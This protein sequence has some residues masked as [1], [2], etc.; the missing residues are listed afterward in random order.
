MADSEDMSRESAAARRSA[1]RSMAT[2]PGELVGGYELLR[3][4]GRGGM[5]EVWVARKA[6]S[7][8]GKFVALKM[9]LPQFVGDE[10]YSRMFR[11]EAEV[12]A[13]LSHSNIVQVFDEGEDA[14]RS[15]LV[16]EWVDGVDLARLAPDLANLRE[17]DPQ[18]RLRVI[19]YVVGQVLHGLS[20]AHKITSHRGQSLGIV[21]RD[22]SPQ[23]VIVSV[24]GDVKVTD[25]GIAHRMIEETSGIHVKGKL[26]YMAPEHLAGQSHSPTVDLYAVGAILH[27]LLEGRK[28]RH[29]AQDQVQLYHQ[30]MTG[31]IPD[32]PADAPR[33]L[34]DLRLALLQPD[35]KKRPQ[36]AD[37]ALLM[38]KRWPGYSEMKVEL[39]MICGM[40]TGI[41]RPRT[42]PAITG[43]SIVPPTP[44][45][46]PEIRPAAGTPVSGTAPTAEQHDAPAP[47]A[48]ATDEAPPATEVIDPEVLRQH[49]RP[50]SEPTVALAG[51]ASTG[52]HATEPAPVDPRD[53][54][55]THSSIVG[56]ASDPG[57]YGTT[58]HVDATISRILIPAVEEPPRRR[59][60]IAVVG[61]AASLA[62]LAGGAAAWFLASEAEPDDDAHVLVE[63]RP[64][65]TPLGSTAREPVVA[66]PS[67]APVDAAPKPASAPVEPTPAPIAAQPTA[68]ASAEPS[69]PASTPAP[70]PVEPKRAEDRRSTTP[71]KPEP[72]PTGP[73]VSV[74]YRLEGGLEY[75]EVKI[76]GVLMKLD[77]RY[78]SKLPSGKHSV[79]WRERDGRWKSGSVVIGAGGEWKIWVGPAGV[80]AEKL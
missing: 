16:M 20:Y 14:G 56:P 67:L 38:L 17:R 15:F 28:F 69:T 62:V 76:G 74:H 65:P 9:I 40:M 51:Q 5:A 25:F 54:E 75:A 43:G 44:T 48:I 35:P 30:V 70:K 36:T 73:P 37:A 39:G 7:I 49:H 26:R 77:P 31:K 10:R 29:D 78:D 32:A 2:E 27:E 21:H 63:P 1:P 47:S 6:N 79:K 24:S 68:P 45:A 41:V 55:P 18:L 22:V 23:N 46:T 61:V 12:S 50:R 34:E 59:V 53:L 4:I 58:P 8:G 66:G 57:P 80:R 11:S 60:W 42:G 19:A 64:V 72:A 33:E 13:P 52:P 71:P 3:E